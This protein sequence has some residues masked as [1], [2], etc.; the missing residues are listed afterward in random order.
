[1]LTDRFTGR[2]RR[3]LLAAAV[4]TVL[5]AWTAGPAFGITG[6]H[7]WLVVRCRPENVPAIPHTTTYFKNLFTSAGSGTGNMVDWWNDIS[8]G[9]LRTAQTVVADGPHADPNGFYVEP[10]TEDQVGNL[11]RG[12][13][14]A[15]CAA[16]ASQDYNLGLFYGVISLW[17]GVDTTITSNISAH[18]TSIPVAVSSTSPH[19]GPTTM[20]DF[21]TPPF[22][23]V[24]S[25]P[26]NGPSETVTVTAVHGHQLTVQRAQSIIPATA[27]ATGFVENQAVAF[28]SGDEIQTLNDTSYGAASEGQATGL[29][30]SGPSGTQGPFSLGLVN[31]PLNI[32]P[33]GAAHEMGHAFGLEHSRLLSTS[34]AG[35]SD[36]YDDM[37]AFAG[38]YSSSD[39]IGSDN[40][41]YGGSNLGSNV[42]S[43]GPG[44]DA[45]QLDNLGLIPAGREFAPIII[46]QQT[47]ELHSLTDTDALHDSQPLSGGGLG[48]GF[49]ELRAP[50]IKP[51][52]IAFATATA[53]TATAPATPKQTC[54]SDYYTLEYRES[55]GVWDS[56][57]PS[58]DQFWSPHNAALDS[59]IKDSDFPYGSVI[60]D[61][62]CPAV[63]AQS[64]G[65]VV[66]GYDW[67]A[68]KESSSFGPGVSHNSDLYD[69]HANS[70]DPGAF[71]PGDEYRDV[72]NDFYLGVNE[73][74]RHP[75]DAVITLANGPIKSVF[76]NVGP[77]FARLDSSVTL[78]ADLHAVQTGTQTLASDAV[79][80]GHLVTFK[81]GS[82]TCSAE[83][84]LDGKASCSLTVHGKLGKT[85]LEV[86]AKSTRAYASATASGTVDVLLPLTHPVLGP[87]LKGIHLH[88]AP[89]PRPEL[90]PGV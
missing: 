41:A 66:Y 47:F 46:K 7:P 64:S 90:G 21:P 32:N 4:P 16:E 10:L 14:V 58:E 65:N 20:N 37:S 5:L 28:K 68:D 67:L 56:G 11:N 81:L 50:T 51:I 72:K 17:P 80:P 2:L 62:H 88:H 54:D 55:T 3:A 29:S 9:Q 44:L 83:T 36:D 82:Q 22:G 15:A 75:R 19:P 85:K 74:L 18:A 73:D 76:T 38:T 71:W 25:P 43:K 79:V 24:I 42:G 30:F 87:V 48:D 57:I 45:I 6:E 26:N 35:Y 8:F 12:Q 59:A 52:P 34:T 31:L 33:T 23:M 89:L 61:L 69:G 27:P 49:L 63:A 84:A 13:Q 60:L 70:F 78:K 40:R 53:A 77:T 1:M 39:K 86:T